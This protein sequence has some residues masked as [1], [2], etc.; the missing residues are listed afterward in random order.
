[1][2]TLQQQAGNHAVQALLRKGLIQ[3]KLTVSNP[4]DPEEVEADQVADRVM[5]SHA[6]FPASSSCSCASGG[7]M[8][9]E[10]QQKQSGTV[11]RKPDGGTGIGSPHQSVEHG[12]RSSGQPLAPATR[13][14]FEPHFGTDLGN[15]RVHADANAAESAR[16]INALAYTVGRDIVFAEGQYQ[17]GTAAGQRLMAHELT[18]V[19]QQRRQAGP[20]VQRKV[21]FDNC[22]ALESGVHDSHN[23]ATEMTD[24]TIAALRAYDGTNPAN[25]RD[26][27]N[28]H[29][30]AT[31][32]F[33]AGIVAD[34][35]Q[36]CRDAAQDAQYE[37][38]EEQDMGGTLAE[39]LW[40]VP[41]TDIKL[42]K[43]FFK[44][45]EDT[46]GNTLVHE[47][48]HRYSC[49]FDLGYDWEPI[50][51]TSGTVRALANAEP[52]GNIVQALGARH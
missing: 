14:F 4:G 9:E 36:K 23:H 38:H 27:L 28:T 35:L 42:F 22:E 24:R 15:V 34:N 41:L 2:L 33:I 48:L 31:S 29:F 30:H 11:A 45:D 16:S 12:L 51:K 37:C 19:M 32:K 6:G 26:A 1:V 8:C 5:R 46:K 13:S 17:P 39:S 20:L 40:C 49:K 25:V 52:Y 10:C 21:T 47:W 50:Y 44:K 3:A 7:D 18:H 43:G